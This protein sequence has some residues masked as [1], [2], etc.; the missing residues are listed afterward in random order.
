MSSSAVMTQLEALG[1]PL[2]FA[3]LVALLLP[4]VRWFFG[5][6]MDSFH[7][8]RESKHRDREHLLKIADH[9]SDDPEADWIREDELQSAFKRRHGIQAGPEERRAYSSLLR[10]CSPSVKWRHIRG[11]SSLASRS[12]DGVSIELRMP[13]WQRRLRYGAALAGTSVYLLGCALW[14]QGLIPAMHGVWLDVIVGVALAIVGA[15]ATRT[16]LFPVQSYDVVAKAICGKERP[17]ILPIPIPEPVNAGR[18][19]TPPLT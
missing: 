13:R 18:T 11:I 7:R 8:W 12:R 2:A 17:D 16:F 9:R 14:V 3:V 6:P 19:T 10:R 1:V 4:V 15:I 5:P